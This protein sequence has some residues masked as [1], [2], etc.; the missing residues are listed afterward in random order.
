MRD[1]MEFNKIKT[2]VKELFSSRLIVV[3]NVENSEISI[4]INGKEKLNKW[5]K[6]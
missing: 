5:K 6:K 2:W 3:K 4:K 1:K